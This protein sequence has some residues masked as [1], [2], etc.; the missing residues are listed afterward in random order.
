MHNVPDAIAIAEYPAGL[1][2]IPIAFLLSFGLLGAVRTWRALRRRRAFRDF[3]AAR[4]LQFVGTIPSDAR[5]PYTRIDKVRRAVLLWNVIEGQWD[6][7]PVRLFDMPERFPRGR[8]TTAILVTVG[9]ILDRGAEAERA[10][11][12]IP[13]VRIRDELRRR[14][15]LAHATTRGRGAGYMAV[16]G[17]H[18]R[19][20][21]GARREGGGP[22]RR[23]DRRASSQ[24]GHVRHA[25]RGVRPGRRHTFFTVFSQACDIPCVQSGRGGFEP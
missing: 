9:D 25:R 23:V 7:L 6:G 18:D 13:K 14:L 19:Q 10:I 1:S 15:R 21:D 4:H 24:P 12:A 16:V 3:A 22:A 8:R 2:V 20:G 17:R 11:T 5:A